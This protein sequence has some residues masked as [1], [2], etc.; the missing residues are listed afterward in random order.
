MQQP[1]EAWPGE[2]AHEGARRR[3]EATARR[4]REKAGRKK[5]KPRSLKV[6]LPV[7][8]KRLAK[9]AR[10][11]RRMAALRAGGR[12]MFAQGI[13]PVAHYAAEHDAW[14]TGEVRWMQAA[15]L[16]R[17][18]ASVLRHYGVVGVWLVR[19]FSVWNGASA[20]Q[21]IDASTLSP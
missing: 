1:A 9:A 21:H 3:R 5:I 20:L 10:R 4:A 2:L 14:G 18:G 6:A 7:R 17:F 8:A 11:L 13:F 12:R 16:Q 19:C 15:A